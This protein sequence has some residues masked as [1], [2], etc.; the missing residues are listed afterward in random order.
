MYSERFLFIVCGSGAGSVFACL[1]SV[2]SVL[3]RFRCGVRWASDQCTCLAF[4]GVEQLI[5]VPNSR[6]GA[7]NSLPREL[8]M[9]LSRC[10]YRVFIGFRSNLISFPYILDVFFLGNTISK[11]GI[12]WEVKF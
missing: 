4:G 9:G 11:Q 12:R 2:V 3:S 10:T 7:V 1:L 8:E 5:Y 6:R